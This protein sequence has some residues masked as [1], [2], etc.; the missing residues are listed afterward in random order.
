VAAFFSGGV[1]SWSTVLDHPEITDLIFV[2]GIDLLVDAPHQQALSRQAEDRLRNVVEEL[3]LK[4][5]AVE[6]NLRQLTDPL[7]RWETYFGA[8]LGAVSLFLGPR[9]ER[10]L[11]AGSVDYEVQETF[12]G[13][14]LVD[15]L[16]STELLEVLEDGGR[17]S[18]VERT[19]RIASHSVVQR[20]LRVCWENPD[21][22]Y[23]CGR[24][25]KCLMTMVTLEAL[26]A[27]DLVK[28]FPPEL[29]LEAVASIEISLV[30]SLNLWED[31]LDAI[32][33][34]GRTDLEPP[35]EAA[36]ENGKRRLGLPPGYRRR[37]RPGPLP[38]DPEAARAARAS[39]EREAA[40]G[41]IGTRRLAAE[42]LSSNSWKLTE[43]LRRAR[44]L[45]R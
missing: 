11:I 39:R 41:D 7:A 45:L 6:T 5:H 19:A 32:R 28:T 13:T 43:P 23:N 22:A 29:D 3:G 18:R 38:L 26:G 27:R 35:V 25:R 1:D 40:L 33:D 21:G 31:M 2:R 44:A 34:A 9:F 20:S 14:R 24:C 12:G 4:F 16:W 37:A 36:V 8:A 30:V 17:Y 42:V 10:V 15:Q